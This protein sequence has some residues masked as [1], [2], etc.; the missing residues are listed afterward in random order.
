IEEVILNDDGSGQVTMTVNLSQSKTKVK[1]IMLMDSVNSYKVPS[2]ADI[3]KN[4]DRLVAEI[5]SVD[6]VSNVQK[7]L[8]FDEFIFTLSCDFENVEVLNSVIV[9][10]STD[11]Y[12]SELNKN[13][14]FAYDANRKVFTRNYHYNLAQE[15]ERVKESDKEILE[16]ASI[17]TIYRFES[18][19]SSAAN[20]DSR[21]AGNKKAVMLKVN[22][23]DMISN[24]KNIK[25]S[26]TLQ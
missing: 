19:I 20:E 21:I 12:K 22:V 16:D 6:G 2:E 18:D 26:I 24:K 23:P 8:N 25:N 10:F 4:M 7:T 3:R 1:S 14:Q 17:T 9:H 11:N 15:I 5:Q 13:K